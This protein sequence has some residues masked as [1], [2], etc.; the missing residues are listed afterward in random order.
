M[1]LR[2]ASR[3]AVRSLARARIWPKPLPLPPKAKSKRISSCSLYR[4]STRS[5]TVLS[6]ATCL[7]AWSSTSRQLKERLQT[8]NMI[9]IS[10]PPPSAPKGHKYFEND[11]IAEPC[12]WGRFLL[13]PWKYLDL[14]GTMRRQACRS[15]HPNVDINPP[16]ATAVQIHV[17]HPYAPAV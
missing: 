14:S 7:R 11:E 9:R 5:S 15:R 1:L 16:A 17:P 12:F 2:T 6:M 3:Y 4:R 13:E 10:P 8:Q